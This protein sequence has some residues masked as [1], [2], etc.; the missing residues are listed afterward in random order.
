MAIGQ[1]PLGVRLRDSSVFASYFGGRNGGVVGTLLALRDGEGPR[2]IY[3]HGG[4]G[5]GKSHLLQAACAQ[6]TEQDRT[7][8]YLSLSDPSL[9]PEMLAGL[10]AL[11]L[12]CVDDIEA[13]AGAADWERALFS[14]Y[15][16]IED[17]RGRLWVGGRMP[18][19]ALGIRLRDLASRLGGGLVLTLQPLEEHECIEALQL[20]ARMRGLELPEDAVQYL[21]RR[22]PRDMGSLCAVLDQLDEAS[23]AAQRRLTVPFVRQIIEG[24][25]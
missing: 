12:V 14:L 10:G 19:A 22:L 1:L 5:V 23:L 24:G 4:A 8:A 6:A 18:P 11:Q 21:L 20:R 2:C 3:L 9:R 15:Q 7:A 13:I 25:V 17:Q 16:E